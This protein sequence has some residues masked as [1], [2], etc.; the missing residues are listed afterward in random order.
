MESDTSGLDISEL[1]EARCRIGPALADLRAQ[2]RTA[3]P[4]QRCGS[5]ARGGG[6]GLTPVLVSGYAIQH[7]L[8]V[9]LPRDP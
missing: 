7:V 1:L 9:P 2:Q 4:S 5:D 3:P 8:V 6:T